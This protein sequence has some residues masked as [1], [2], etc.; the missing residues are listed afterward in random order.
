MNFVYTKKG[1]TYNLKNLSG[2]EDYLL[3]FHILSINDTEDIFGH[4]RIFRDGQQ[5]GAIHLLGDVCF[6]A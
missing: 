1:Y 2:F 5:I 3:G 4:F 6:M